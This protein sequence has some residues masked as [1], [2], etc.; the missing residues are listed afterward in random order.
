MLRVG[1]I[2]WMPNTMTYRRGDVV[3]VPFPFSNQKGTKKRPAVVVDVDEEME[4][5]VVSADYSNSQ[6]DDLIIAQISSMFRRPL[7][8]D[9]YEIVDW[10]KAELLRPSVVRPKLATLEESLVIRPLG[11][12]TDEDMKEVDD[13]LRMV[14]AL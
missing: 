2:H 12:L 13:R 3:L 5:V 8:P 9:E 10:E 11:R 14:L 1:I 4:G 7:P 6:Q